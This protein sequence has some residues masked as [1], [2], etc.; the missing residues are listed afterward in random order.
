M[1]QFTKACRPSSGARGNAKPKEC[2][3][4]E[5]KGWT[6]IQTQVRCF[7]IFDRFFGLFSP[8]RSP[9]HG[10]VQHGLNVPSATVKVVN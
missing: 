5:G 4:C 1:L 6:F 9:R 8:S 2:V 7:T 10:T 3:N